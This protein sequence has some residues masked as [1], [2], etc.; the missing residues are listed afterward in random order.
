MLEVL[1]LDAGVC[2]YFESFHGIVDMLGHFEVSVPEAGVDD[3]VE[4]VDGGS[5]DIVGFEL[6]YYL[7][8][9]VEAEVL[10][11]GVLGFES[12]APDHD[13][14]EEDKDPLLPVLAM[15]DDLSPL[16]FEFTSLLFI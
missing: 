11:F 3:E 8:E 9:L 1:I 4:H 7:G 6:T 14:G 15:N 13:P 5:G 16:R 12:A 10:F 2:T